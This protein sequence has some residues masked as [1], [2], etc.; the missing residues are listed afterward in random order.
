FDKETY[1]VRMASVARPPGTIE[2]TDRELTLS[3][4]AHTP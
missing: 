2:I 4:T 3:W 1:G